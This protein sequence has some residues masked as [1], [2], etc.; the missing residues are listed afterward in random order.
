MH[1]PTGKLAATDENDV[2]NFYVLPFLLWVIGLMTRGISA[3]TAMAEE[4]GNGVY[5]PVTKDRRS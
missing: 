4:S 1:D 2:E 3:G 5:G